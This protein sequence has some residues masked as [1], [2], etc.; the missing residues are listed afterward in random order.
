MAQKEKEYNAFYVQCL[1]EITRYSFHD[2]TYFERLPNTEDR[3]GYLKAVAMRTN[4]DFGAVIFEAK[5]EPFESRNGNK[6]Q[7]ISDPI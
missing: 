1:G 6:L 3:D 7:W 5:H 4:E 2:L